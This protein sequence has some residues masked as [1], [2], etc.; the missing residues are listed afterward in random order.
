MAD[1]AGELTENFDYE[2]TGRDMELRGDIY[3]ITTAHDEVHIFWS[4]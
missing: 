3:T 1:Y 2:K 4:H